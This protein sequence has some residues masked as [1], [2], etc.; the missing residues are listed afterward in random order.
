[1]SSKFSTYSDGRHVNSEDPEETPDYF[2]VEDDDFGLSPLLIFKS[3]AAYFA[4]NDCC[5]GHKNRNNITLHATVSV[6]STL[7]ST[8]VTTYVR[9]C[10]CMHAWVHICVCAC[11]YVHVCTCVS[12]SV[13]VSAFVCLCA[14]VCIH[15]YV[16]VC[17]VCQL[18]QC[19]SVSVYM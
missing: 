4:R 15:M 17:I 11:V 13:S 18:C 6:S 19:V 3:T 14:F 12:V 8:Y 9:M 1:M 5:H 7:Y 2:T 10:V 16:S